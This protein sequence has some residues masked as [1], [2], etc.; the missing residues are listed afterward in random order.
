LQVSLAATESIRD[1][2]AMRV[3]TLTAQA[4]TVAIALASRAAPTVFSFS[5]VLSLY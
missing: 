2:N 1:L 5:G 4:R 3:K